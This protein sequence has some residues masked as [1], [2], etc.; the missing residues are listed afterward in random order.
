MV[1]RTLEELQ[2]YQ[3]ALKAAAEISAILDRP[4]LR[5]DYGLRRQIAASSSS[6][7]A[8]ISEGFGQGTDRHC[9]HFQRIARGSANEIRS[10]L[11]VAAGRQ[12]ITKAELDR[13]DAMYVSIGK[14]LTRWIQHLDR[15]D[16]QHRG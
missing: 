1:I 8:Q 7:S 6:V 4:R 9:A 2:V 5:R 12:Y 14:M 10:H 15:V 13:F 16:R 3:L 11:A